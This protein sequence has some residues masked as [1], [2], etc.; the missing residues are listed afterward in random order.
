[1]SYL[2]GETR[3][4][5]APKVHGM[6]RFWDTLSQKPYNQLTR[7]VE[8]ITEP[9]LRCYG[10][11]SSYQYLAKLAYFCF[12]YVKCYYHVYQKTHTSCRITCSIAIDRGLVRSVRVF[13]VQCQWVLGWS[14]VDDLFAE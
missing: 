4:H 13:L 11:T 5:F 7:L 3:A 6:K 9:K 12:L 10:A 1:M 2:V 14:N 8:K